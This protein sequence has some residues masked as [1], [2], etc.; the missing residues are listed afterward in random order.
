[1]S[2]RRT[3]AVGPALLLALALLT[4]CGS[5]GFGSAEPTRS[6]E[7]VKSYVALGDGF[8]SAP[9]L[10]QDASGTGCRRSADNYPSQ[11]ARA[12]KVST[13]TDVTCLGATT[14]DLT[15][16]SQAPGSG[17][18]LA[19]QFDA[20]TATTDLVTIGIGIE[21]GGLLHN[22]FHICVANPCGK[23]VLGP[24]IKTQLNSYGQAITAGIR[25]IQDI[26]P[27]ATIVVVGYPQLMPASGLCNGLPNITSVQ[28][29]YAYTVLDT[30][31]GLL[32]SAAQQTGSSYI[33]VADLSKDHTV[34]SSQPWINPYTVTKGKAQSLHPLPVEQK[35]VADAIV[36]VVGNAALT[37]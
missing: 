30:L 6:A 36:D 25:T 31:N 24:S 16:K 2:A 13:V 11:V 26:A 28:L 12:L 9:Y 8:A 18:K 3:R 37:K 20:V 22:M 33:D 21:D 1:M 27:K 23:D 7:P 35:A 32:R 14:K 34:C 19:A 15:N 4:G 17:K 10:G 29:G 5:G